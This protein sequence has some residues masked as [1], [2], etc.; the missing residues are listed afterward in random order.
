MSNG[1][2]TRKTLILEVHLT[3]EGD[4]IPAEDCAGYAEQWI[5][6]GLNDRDDLIRWTVV[7]QGDVKEVEL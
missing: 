2:I 7:Q 5:D 4:Y 6:A 1:P 3:F